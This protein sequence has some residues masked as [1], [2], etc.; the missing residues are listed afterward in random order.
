MGITIWL[1]IASVVIA[2]FAL[3]LSI[4]NTKVNNSYSHLKEDP[5]FVLIG[6]D[7][8]SN[9]SFKD[10]INPYTYNFIFAHENSEEL[11]KLEGEKY[12]K[13]LSIT[14]NKVYIELENCGGTGKDLTVITET[15]MPESLKTMNQW[16][17]SIFSHGWKNR[18]KKFA[19]GEY[20]TFTE[21]EG[22][23]P[24]F[25]TKFDYLEG[26]RF[27]KKYKGIPSGGKLKLKLPKEFMFFS[28]IH[29]LDII[30]EVPTVKVTIKGT[31]TLNKKFEDSMQIMLDTLDERFDSDGRYVKVSLMSL[32][33]EDNE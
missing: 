25:G 20:A 11:I 15:L 10:N 30:N 5:F 4:Y 6:K 16:S 23:T 9:Y 28:N 12:R 32:M 3:G 13:E 24:N 8:E 26:V 29:H 14:K 2:A 21:K 1:S 18:T 7:Y 31:N 17:S 27:I 19:D 33:H 22:E